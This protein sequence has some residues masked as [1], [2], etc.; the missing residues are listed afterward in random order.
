MIRVM[1]VEDNDPLRDALCA[2]LGSELGIEIVAACR[3]GHEAVEQ[4]DLEPDVVV[5]DL[6]MPRLD[7]VGLTHV[8]SR[9]EHRHAVRRIETWCPCCT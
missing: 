8:A 2:S 5:T 9:P 7:G 3:D 6:A 1:V 4:L